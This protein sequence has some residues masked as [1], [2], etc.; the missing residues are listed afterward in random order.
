MSD[1]RERDDDLLQRAR[2]HLRRAT[3]EGLEASSALLEAALRASSLYPAAA[4]SLAGELQRNLENLIEAVERQQDFQL[5]AALSDPLARALDAEIARWEARSQ[6]DPNARPVL[7]AFLGLREL[8]WE[9]G[10]RGSVHAAPP[11]E[12]NPSRSPDRPRPASPR[13]VQRFDVEH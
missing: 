8:L 9:F 13:R 12:A 10:V 7:R 1:R 11:P 6:T 5:P 2:N 3:V 4:D